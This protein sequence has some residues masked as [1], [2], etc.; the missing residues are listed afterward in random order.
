[1]AAPQ[2][3]EPQFFAATNIFRRHKQLLSALL[4]VAASLPS[5]SLQNSVISGTVACIINNLPVVVYKQ[6]VIRDSGM[7]G[8]CLSQRGSPPPSER[9]AS[10]TKKLSQNRRCNVGGPDQGRVPAELMGRGRGFPYLDELALRALYVSHM[11]RGGRRAP[12]KGSP[13]T[14][15][16]SMPLLYARGLGFAPAPPQ[17]TRHP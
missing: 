9:S 2:P 5:G 15:L 12:L 3:R 14:S 17:R 6:E 16:E 10:S 7:T 1:M 11:I 4:A 13:P 8:F